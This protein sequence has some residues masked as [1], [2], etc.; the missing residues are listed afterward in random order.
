MGRDMGVGTCGMDGRCR[1]DSGSVVCI[2]VVP[3]HVQTHFFH[4]PVP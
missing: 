2:A 4:G 3:L 1:G